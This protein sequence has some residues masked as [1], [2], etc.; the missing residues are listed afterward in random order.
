MPL[1]WVRDGA[2]CNVRLTRA[3]PQIVAPSPKSR[4]SKAVWLPEVEAPDEQAAM[5]KAAAARCQPTD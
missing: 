3:L 5:E 4:L 2:H 1:R